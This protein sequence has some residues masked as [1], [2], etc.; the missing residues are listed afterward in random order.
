MYAKEAFAKSMVESY[1]KAYHKITND[2]TLSA[3]NLDEIC[4][5]EDNIN[6]VAQL[7]LT[8]LAEQ[9]NGTVKEAIKNS[10]NKQ[11]CTHFDEPSY[12]D[13]HHFY[14]NLRSNIHR[15]RLQNS[16]YQQQ[17]INRLD[18]LLQEGCQ[19]IEHLVIANATGRN[20]SQAGGLSIYFPEKRIHSSYRRAGFAQ[21]EWITLLTHYLI[22]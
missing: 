5:L 6:T 20:L 12:I 16:G 13:L 18:Q 4:Y 3:V 22:L 19:I 14:K 1:E 8:A 17:L 15:F 21:N 9:K 10:R 2:F 11:L 7:L